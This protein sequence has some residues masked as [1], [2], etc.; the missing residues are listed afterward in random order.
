MKEITKE[1]GRRLLEESAQRNLG[2]SAA[3]FICRWEAG[4]LHGRRAERVSMLLPLGR[5][6]S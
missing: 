6:S 2:I 3:E 1:E 4:E 5:K